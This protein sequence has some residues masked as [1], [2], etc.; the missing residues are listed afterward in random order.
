[1][2]AKDFFPFSFDENFK[3]GVE[4]FSAQGCYQWTI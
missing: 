3:T 2:S 4:R 1:M